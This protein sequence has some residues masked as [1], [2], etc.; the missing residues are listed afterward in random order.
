MSATSFSAPT[1]SQNNAET[2]Q[3]K[4]ALT[5]LLRF[6]FRQSSMNLRFPAQYSSVY[7]LVTIH[8]TMTIQFAMNF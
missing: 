5:T 8:R 1:L 3:Y 6:A 7:S 2:M 4:I